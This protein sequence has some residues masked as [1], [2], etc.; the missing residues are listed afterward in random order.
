M[1][2]NSAASG[3]AILILFANKNINIRDCVF[4]NNNAFL[5][6]GAVQISY[7]NND[8]AFEGLFFV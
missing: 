8:I 6:G 4:E 3:G 7:N 2:G 5:A 1:S